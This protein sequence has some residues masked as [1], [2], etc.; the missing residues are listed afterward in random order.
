MPLPTYSLDRG[1]SYSDPHVQSCWRWI[2]NQLSTNTKLRL[3]VPI[4]ACATRHS[5]VLG[6]CWNAELSVHSP[7]LFT[8]HDAAGVL[9][10]RINS[11][12]VSFPLAFADWCLVRMRRRLY[13]LQLLAA[14]LRRRIG[15]GSLRTD[16]PTQR[17]VLSSQSGPSRQNWLRCPGE[18]IMAST[19]MKKAKLTHQSQRCLQ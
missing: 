12:P 7:R 2:Q 9:C 16:K 4:R 8:F 15:E 14:S 3:T 18:I 10:H 19:Q 1:A 17:H 6:G 13:F 11:L 5:P